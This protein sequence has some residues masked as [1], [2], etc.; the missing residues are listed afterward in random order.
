MIKWVCSIG[1]DEFAY[2]LQQSG[3]HGAVVAMDET[4]DVGSL[5]YYLQIPSTN[6]QASVNFHPVSDV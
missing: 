1:L 2:C 6:T 3:I 5:T 4:F